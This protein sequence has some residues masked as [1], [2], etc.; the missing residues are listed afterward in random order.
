LRIA[1]IAIGKETQKLKGLE[2]QIQKRYE[3]LN[4]L[5]KI[6]AGHEQS[7]ANEVDTILA[8][9]GQIQS[10]GSVETGTD[11]SHL[12]NVFREDENPHETGIFTDAILK[13]APDREGSYIKV[14][15]IL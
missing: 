9:V 10:I 6:F 3:R 11:V 13:A 15:K 1:E 4:Q 14:K 2:E 8:Y 7:L 12:Q 5:N